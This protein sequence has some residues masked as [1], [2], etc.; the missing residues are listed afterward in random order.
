MAGTSSQPDYQQQII[1]EQIRTLYQSTWSLIL[2]N[3]LVSS[4]LT[5]SFWDY[6][7]HQR[8][9]L[10]MGLMLLMLA[11]RSLFYWQ[12]QRDFDASLIDRYRLLLLLGSLFAGIIWGAGGIL[13]FPED[14]FEYQLFLLLSFLAMTGGSTFS[15][16]I[17]LPAYFA[18]VPLSLLPITIKLFGMMEAV[19]LALGMITVVFFAAL[20]SFN[21]RLNRS[22]TQSLQLRY[23]N[24]DLIEQL[25]IQKEEAER[26]NKAKSKFLA[27]ASHDLRQPLYSLTLFT[28][29]LEELVK[30]EKPREVVDKI[31]QSVDS[32]QDL[33]DKLLDISQLDAGVIEANKTA[34]DMADLIDTLAHDF[35][36]PAAA[37]GLTMTWPTEAITVYS[38]RALLEQ[39]LRNFISNAIRYTTAGTVS[40]NY[41]YS[42]DNVTIEVADTGIGIAE[43]SLQDIFVEFHQ[44]DNSAR[45]R[46][47]GLGLGLSIVQR[48]AALLEHPIALTSTPGAGSTFSVT[49]A[50][51][52]AQAA[53]M[54]PVKKRLPGKAFDRSMLVVIID[55]EQA[56][57]D[58]LSQLLMLWGCSVISAADADTCLDLLRSDGREPTAIISDFR[59]QH[60]KTGI[61]AIQ[62]LYAYYQTDFPALLMTGDIEKEQLVEID[63]SGIQVLYKPVAPNKLRGFLQS[64][65]ADKALSQ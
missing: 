35:N 26:A 9:L 20:T 5:F 38:E 18:Y 50:R 42:G 52:P 21:Y 37:K 59:L 1:V 4:I 54:A 41:E 43:S 53:S 29:V 10:W 3:L 22:F 30:E 39:I 33:F 8:L 58:G 24:L 65:S 16:S 25:N 17:Y 60:N 15:L 45:E 64:A 27:A 62:A 49:L 23:E 11:V 48:S 56:I 61:D 2:I 51:A 44:L 63:S 40:L 32:L 47:K 28:S 6:V 46:E 55:D 31:H 34:V 36:G 7:D 12:F 19:Y 14:N 13:L 57:R